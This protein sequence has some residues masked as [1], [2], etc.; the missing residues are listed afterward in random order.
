M[1]AGPWPGK[2]FVLCSLTMH[3]LCNQNYSIG[4]L[5]SMS[6]DH[7][8]LYFAKFSL[9]STPKIANKN[10]RQR[11]LPGFRTI[12]FINHDSTEEFTL[13]IP[14][15]LSEGIFQATALLNEQKQYKVL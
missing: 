15:H 5:N 9:R 14:H 10:I 3:E 4:C 13:K 1:L 12:P 7:Q 11:P 2:S 6:T 8:L